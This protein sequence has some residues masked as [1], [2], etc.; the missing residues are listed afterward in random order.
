MHEGSYDE[1]E[2]RVAKIVNSHENLSLEQ[3]EQFE[4]DHDVIL[5]EKYKRFLLQWNGGYPE[6][7]VFKISDEQGASVL[8]V[9]NGIGDMYDNLEKV[10]GIYEDRFPAGFI[11]IG[12]DPGGNVICIG[13]KEPYYEKIY[14]WD[15]EEESDEPDDRTN[16]YVL[17]DDIY[18]FLDQLYDD[19]DSND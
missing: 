1:G 18:E 11:P 8:H 5:P 10:M 12:D 15:H 2:F 14:F 7:S 6:P 4:A 3:I 9:L 13:T 16:M 17:A 19:A